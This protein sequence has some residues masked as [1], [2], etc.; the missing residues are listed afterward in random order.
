MVRNLNLL[1]SG[2]TSSSSFGRVPAARQAQDKTG[3]VGEF[4]RNFLFSGMTTSAVGRAPV[5]REAHEIGPDED[6]DDEDDSSSSWMDPVSA[7]EPR[8]IP[9]MDDK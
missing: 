7:S 4:V 3:G 2:M 8:I 1:L 6:N 5:V 9:G